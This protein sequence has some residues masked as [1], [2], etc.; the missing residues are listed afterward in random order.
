MYFDSGNIS[1]KFYFDESNKKAG[2]VELRIMNAEI[3][4]SINKRTIKKR[5]EYK[6][7]Q[8]FEVEDINEDLQ[9]ELVWDYCITDW[10]NLVDDK[11]KAVPCNKE[12][13]IMYMTKAPKFMVFVNKCMSELEDGL[14]D[15]QADLEK[16]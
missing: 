12:N 6:R 10:N 13:K 14:H 7:G 1:T 8:R 16:N 2:Y 3:L 15:L 11:G 9:S 5:I 4:K